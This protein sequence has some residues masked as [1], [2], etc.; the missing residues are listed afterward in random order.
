M[1]LV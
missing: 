1:Y